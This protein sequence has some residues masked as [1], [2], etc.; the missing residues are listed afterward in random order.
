MLLMAGEYRIKLSN[1]RH[2]SFDFLSNNKVIEF[3]GDL[4]H[5]NPMIFSESDVV[6]I[7]RHMEK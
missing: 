1:G 4:W 2:V 5:A 7:G 6:N 3:N